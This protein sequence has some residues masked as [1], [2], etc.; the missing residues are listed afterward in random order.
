MKPHNDIGSLEFLPAKQFMCKFACTVLLPVVCMLDGD[1]AAQ[2]GGSTYR[3]ELNIGL[4]DL[5]S[6]LTPV[7]YVHGRCLA[8]QAALA[9]AFYMMHVLCVRVPLE[10]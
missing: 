2:A 4:V 10:K 8:L 6:E 5:N 7:L 1:S 3:N 9:G